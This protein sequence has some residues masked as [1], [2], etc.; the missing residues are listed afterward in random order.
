MEQKMLIKINQII[1]VWN[2]RENMKHIRERYHIEMGFK[3]GHEILKHYPPVEI[4]KGVIDRDEHWEMRVN[5][6]GDNE[7]HDFVKELVHK[8]L[9][10]NS[11][12]EALEVAKAHFYNHMSVRD[13]N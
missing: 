11:R 10:S 9:V 8:I 6:I 3:M 5:T 13:A 4:G 12:K 2:S 7:L 1:P